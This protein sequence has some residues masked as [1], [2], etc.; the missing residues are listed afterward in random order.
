[1]PDGEG[2]NIAQLQ[3]GFKVDWS[4]YP[5][6]PQDDFVKDKS[7]DFHA[8]VRYDHIQSKS[9]LPRRAGG[10][11]VEG[12][13]T[14]FPLEGGERVVTAVDAIDVDRQ[15]QDVTYYNLMGVG[16]EHPFAGINLVVTRY[17]DGTQKTAKHI[18]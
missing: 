10:E 8:I 9:R 5:G 4:L 16:S 13:Y 2:D 11:V 17:S 12:D 7:Y 14:V 3:G 6:T 15:V 18:Y 1:M